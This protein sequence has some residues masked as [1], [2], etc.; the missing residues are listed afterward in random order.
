MWFVVGQNG[1]VG[2][3]GLRNQRLSMHSGTRLGHHGIETVN[4]IGS[5]VHSANGAIGLNQRVLTCKRERKE[6]RE[7]QQKEGV[8]K[9]VFGMSFNLNFTLDNIAI[10]RFMLRFHI[11]RGVICHTIVEGVFGMILTRNKRKNLNIE[12]NK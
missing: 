7:R 9:E 4:G 5:I 3:N 11:A 10:T 6:E 12:L 8:K 1:F 2:H